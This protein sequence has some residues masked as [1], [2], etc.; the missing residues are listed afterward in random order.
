MGFWDFFKSKKTL[1]IEQKQ[2]Q[3]IQ[4]VNTLINNLKTINDVLDNIKTSDKFTEIEKQQLNNNTI[5]NYKK[6]LKNF[7]HDEKILIIVLIKN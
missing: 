3:E 4:I 1:E 2:K 7:I 5:Q 6:I